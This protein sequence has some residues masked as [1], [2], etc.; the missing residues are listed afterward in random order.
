MC[1]H[2]MKILNTVEKKMHTFF[3]QHNEKYE[4]RLRINLII[5]QIHFHPEN[6]LVLKRC[7]LRVE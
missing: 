6:M 4:M 5:K 2:N 3:T 7:I 1:Y